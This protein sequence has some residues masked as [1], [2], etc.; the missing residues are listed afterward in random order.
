ML[1]TINPEQNFYIIKG[2][3]TLKSDLVHVD[4]TA[5][6]K[7]I[8][9]KEEKFFKNQIFLK[10]PVYRS[11][12]IR[13]IIRD[14]IFIHL[15]ETIKID[16]KL[17]LDT[18]YILFSGGSLTGGGGT[19]N[20]QKTQELR[21]LFPALSLLGSAIGSQMLTSIMT[22]NALYPV[23][24]EFENGDKSYKE[25]YR[26]HQIVRKDDAKDIL[27]DEYLNQSKEEKKNK[28]P[29][30]M[31]ASFETVKQGTSFDFQLELDSKNSLEISCMHRMIKEFVNFGF[32]GGA[33]RLGFG[34]FELA[35]DTELDSSE[36]DQFI[37]NNAEKIKNYLLDR[38]EG[39][40]L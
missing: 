9:Y 8:F 13:G 14:R 7:S 37:E 26:T 36:Y 1:I 15:L 40:I 16:K 27:A 12:S 19:F 22:T 5:S 10:V 32:V 11:N 39:L 29:Q 21:D 35:L 17:D 33:R 30:Q 25:A 28:K 18:F 34:K 38:K 20:M 3:L 23:C 31:I 4:F 24:K 6:N 2:Q